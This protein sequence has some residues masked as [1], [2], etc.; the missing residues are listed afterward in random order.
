M[1]DSLLTKLLEQS[2][3]NSIR[4]PAID[5]DRISTI[6]RHRRINHLELLKWK[7]KS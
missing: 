4:N 5:T 6:D 7:T 1:V 2:P 3:S